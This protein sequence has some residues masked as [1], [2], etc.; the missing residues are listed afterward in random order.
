MEEILA[1]IR[2]IIADDEKPAAA[3]KTAAAETIAK[4]QPVPAS[5]PAAPAKS[6]AMTAIP[7]VTMT[8]A[9]KPTAD[10]SQDDIDALLAN[11]DA[12]T[13]EEGFVRL[14]PRTQSMRGCLN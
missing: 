2:R 4:P 7:P 9:P 3:A 10:N 8:I 11:L 14:K 13:T 6:A 5:K 12:A 1:S